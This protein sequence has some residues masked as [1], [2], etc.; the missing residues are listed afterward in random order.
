MGDNYTPDWNDIDWNRANWQNLKRHLDHRVELEL[1]APGRPGK[2]IPWKEFHARA[3]ITG[4]Y[5]NRIRRGNVDRLKETTAAK[6]EKAAQWA[7]GSI[8]SV[9]MGGKPTPIEQQELAPRVA[10]QSAQAGSPVSVEGGPGGQSP[11]T[12]ESEYARFHR[13]SSFV[14]NTFTPQAFMQ[15]QQDLATVYREGYQAALQDRGGK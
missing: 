3:G 14:G 8:A 12:A 4:T 13:W 5:I 1:T 10:P 6:I 7:P 2:G 15:L 11:P 9:L